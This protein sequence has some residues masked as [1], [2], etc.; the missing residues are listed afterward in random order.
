MRRARASAT[1]RSGNQDANEHMRT[2]KEISWQSN[3]S[4][5]PAKAVGCIC[6][7]AGS[8]YSLTPR[9]HE[10]CWNFWKINQ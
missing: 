2:T 10:P 8:I 7:C 3:A 1:C 5:T 9:L 4:S 6:A